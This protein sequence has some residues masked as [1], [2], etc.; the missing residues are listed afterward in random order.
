LNREVWPAIVKSAANS[1]LATSGKDVTSGL[2]QFWGKNG[3]EFRARVAWAAKETGLNPG[4]LAANLL[5]E[6]GSRGDY[7]T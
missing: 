4:L 1:A 2:R 6:T 7:L 3:K 5:A